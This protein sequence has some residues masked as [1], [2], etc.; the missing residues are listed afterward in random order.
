MAQYSFVITTSGL[1]SSSVFGAY[2]RIPYLYS[3]YPWTGQVCE[4]R[5]LR[6]NFKL[7]NTV[8]KLWLA[9]EWRVFAKFLISY[10]TGE[11][12]QI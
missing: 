4:K 7:R 3:I 6:S 10:A 5:K 8:E 2:L 9:V 12:V 11:I 1:N